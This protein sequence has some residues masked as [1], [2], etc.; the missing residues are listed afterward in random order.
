ML[1]S[2]TGEALRLRGLHAMYSLENKKLLSKYFDPEMDRL[3]LM[4]VNLKGNVRPY[5]KARLH[6]ASS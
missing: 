3:E 4:H 6:G 2:D 5:S 1:W